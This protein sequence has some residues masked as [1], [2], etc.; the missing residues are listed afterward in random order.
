MNI[1]YLDIEEL[2]RTKNRS[3]DRVLSLELID[4]KAQMSSTG[5]VDRGLFTGDN[6]LHAIMD[7]STCL[8]YCKYERGSPPPALQQKF[9]SFKR[10]FEFVKNYFSKRNINIKEIVD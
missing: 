6:K 10:L 9:T 4:G 1:N 2:R 7:T 5:L 3:I 8:W